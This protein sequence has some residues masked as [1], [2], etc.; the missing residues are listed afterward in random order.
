MKIYK[1]IL[2]ISLTIFSCSKNITENK[3]SNQNKHIQDSLAFELCRIYGSD[4]GIRDIKLLKKRVGALKFSPHLDSINFYKILNFTKNYGYP[5]RNL[6]GE[7]N[8]SYECVQAAAGAVL[9][10]T[11]YMLVNNKE[12]LDMFLNEVEKGHMKRETLALILDKYYLIR[13]DEYGNRK[14]LYGSQFGKPCKMYRRQSDSVRAIIGL[15]P[16][17]DS[18]FIN[19]KTHNK[20]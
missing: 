6:L 16:L 8:F 17:P 15:K 10:H 19:C 5:N 4:Q 3:L 14:L 9:L 7:D 12:Y 11:P 1:F 2:Y 13:R 20:L 18:L